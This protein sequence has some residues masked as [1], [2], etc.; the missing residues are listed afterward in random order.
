MDKQ[1]KIYEGLPETNKENTAITSAIEFL[2]PLGMSQWLIDNEGE[3]LYDAFGREWKYSL[4]K[5]YYKD[6]GDNCKYKEGVFCLHLFYTTFFK[7][8]DLKS[9][10]DSTKV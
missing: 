1:R 8:S 7:K 9:F 5:F 4:F 6:I 10:L 3:V 2:S